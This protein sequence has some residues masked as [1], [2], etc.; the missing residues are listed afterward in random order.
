[1]DA[2]V[3][4]PTLEVTAPSDGNCQAGRRVFQLDAKVSWRSSSG[5]RCTLAAH[6][7]RRQCET[8]LTP[9]A[10][11]VR[12]GWMDRT[13]KRPIYPS[14]KPHTR[15]GFSPPALR[16]EVGLSN[17]GRRRVGRRRVQGWRVVATT[18]GRSVVIGVN[19][20]TTTGRF[21][22]RCDT[23]TP[24]KSDCG[25]VGF[26]QRATA[27]DS[28]ANAS[29]AQV[30]GRCTGL[31]ATVIAMALAMGALQN[32]N[33]LMRWLTPGLLG[34]AFSRRQLNC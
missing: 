15:T 22:N 25:A 26:R 27:F 16:L 3:Y 24:T 1:M 14:A 31:R 29:L 33:V 13:F 23:S 20:M 10:P 12:C 17:G 4:R 32:R 18:T 30:D 28:M 7:R 2:L 11:G 19:T 21:Q 8:T 5:G 34:H 9:F 6:R